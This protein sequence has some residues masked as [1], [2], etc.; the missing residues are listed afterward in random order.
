MTMRFDK[1]AEG[2]VNRLSLQGEMTI[3]HAQ[4]MK[5]HF[6]GALEEAESMQLDLAKVIEI[7]SAGIQ[8]LILLKREAVRMGKTLTVSMHSG[9]TMELIDL[10]N[11]SGFFG[12]PML[13]PGQDRTTRRK[14]GTK[15]T[16]K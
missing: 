8:Q 12:D 3:Y 16:T 9:A 13:I 6:L 7:D 15:G 1:C 4:E 11:L 5:T 2:G 14:S 10:F